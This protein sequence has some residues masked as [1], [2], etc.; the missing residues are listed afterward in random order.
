MNQNYLIQNKIAYN[1]G[2]DR[3]MGNIKLYESLLMNF[4]DDFSFEQITQAYTLKEYRKMFELMHT[5]KGVSGSLGLT[6]L[7]EKACV[8]T[9]ELRLKNYSNIDFLYNDTEKAY[10]ETVSI[11]NNSYDCD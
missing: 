6:V 10:N 11:I 7:Y 4:P 8:L 3:L 9:E 1:E 5:L 2:V